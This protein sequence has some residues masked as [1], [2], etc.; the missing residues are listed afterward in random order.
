MDYGETRQNKSQHASE[1]IQSL[2]SW[3][4]ICYMTLDKT[5]LPLIPACP[6][7]FWS[8]NFFLQMPS[9]KILS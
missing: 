2:Q 7:L 4:Q 3:P 6:K 8:H 9:S 5:L 1:N